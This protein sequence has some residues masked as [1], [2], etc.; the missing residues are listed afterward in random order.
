[1]SCGVGCRYGLDPALLWLWCRLAVVAPTGSLA[2]EHPYA[3]GLAL[4]SRK[5]ETETEEG[6][7]E[8]KKKGRKER[9]N[10]LQPLAK[11]SRVHAPPLLLRQALL[12]H[13]FHLF[14]PLVPSSLDLLQY[15]T[16]PFKTQN[17]TPDKVQPVASLILDPVSLS[18]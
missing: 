10:W 13:K 16:I 4:K 7:K 18:M 1:M 9:R 14:H 3:A 2:W 5:T 15:L 8:G 11:S 12:L 17:R 6:R